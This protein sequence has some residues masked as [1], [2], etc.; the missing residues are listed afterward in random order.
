MVFEG[1]KI[2][3]AVGIPLPRPY[4]REMAPTSTVAR[5]PSFTA[6]GPPRQAGAEDKTDDALQRAFFTCPDNAAA[7]GSVSTRTNGNEL[8]EEKGKIMSFIDETARHMAYKT[9][10]ANPRPALVCKGNCQKYR[11]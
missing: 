10:M 4:R 9:G 2:K 11:S 8:C 1:R 5:Q 7:R 3:P 6:A